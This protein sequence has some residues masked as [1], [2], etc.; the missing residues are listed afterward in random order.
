VLRLNLLGLGL[1]LGADRF[2]G[3]RLPT[4]HTAVGGTHEGTIA[5]RR[6]FA[7]HTLAGLLTGRPELGD[8]LAKLGDFGEQ[9]I[10]WGDLGVFGKGGSDLGYLL[11]FMGELGVIDF[12]LDNASVL[13]CKFDAILLI[14]CLSRILF[15]N[16]E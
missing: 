11:I 9:G 12:T 14:S 3:P 10:H 16:N 15:N 2:G 7:S 6:T 1:L 13:A 5:A 8:F 4:V